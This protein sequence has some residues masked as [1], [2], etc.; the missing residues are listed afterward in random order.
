MDW[1]GICL[2]CSLHIFHWFSKC[3]GLFF[4]YICSV[5]DPFHVDM[6]PGPDPAPNPT[7]NREKKTFF[8]LKCISPK[9][10]LLCYLG[11]NIYIRKHKLNI[12]GY[13]MILV[14]FLWKF[15]MILADFLLPGSVSGSVSD[16]SLE[17]KMPR[18]VQ[19]LRRAPTRGLGHVQGDQIHP[20]QQ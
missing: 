14:E 16:E 17:V 1:P 19:G 7:L 20:S 3:C 6:D 2:L 12:F 11:V 9:N 13:S 5:A 4:L 18:I 8:Y 15:S 10:Y